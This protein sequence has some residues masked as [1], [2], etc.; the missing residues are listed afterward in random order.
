MPCRNTTSGPAP[1]CSTAMRGAGPTRT[2]SV[3]MVRHERERRRHPWTFC[4]ATGVARGEMRALRHGELFGLAAGGA[5]RGHESLGLRNE[6]REIAGSVCD[7]ERR[8]RRLEL[9]AWARQ[10]VGGGIGP[11]EAR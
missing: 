10:P 8:Q 7:Q 3:R 4:L 1:A 5:H 6:M 9:I 11:E 2:I